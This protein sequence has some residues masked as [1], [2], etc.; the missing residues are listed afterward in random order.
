[1]KLIHER[2]TV[3]YSDTFCI[4]CKKHTSSYA[5]AACHGPL[6]DH[7]FKCTIC[8]S[9]WTFITEGDRL[10]RCQFEYSRDDL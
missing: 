8:G 1:M 5:G 2:W 7:N 10:H 6:I 9:A 4:K 3:E